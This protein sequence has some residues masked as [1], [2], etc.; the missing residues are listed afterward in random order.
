[1]L[2]SLALVLALASAAPVDELANW[3][4]ACYGAG[5]KYVGTFPDPQPGLNCI[6]L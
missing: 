6:L 3:Q 4:Y 5:D 2:K 1:M